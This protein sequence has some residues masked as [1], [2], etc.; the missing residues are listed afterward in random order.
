MDWEGGDDIHLCLSP[1]KCETERGGKGGTFS[2]F[3]AEQ[4]KEERPAP[5]SLSSFPPVP[6]PKT[7]NFLHSYPPLH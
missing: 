3:A 2:H 4:R 6:F 1:I 7:P 5:P